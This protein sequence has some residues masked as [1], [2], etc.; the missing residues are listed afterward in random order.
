MMLDRQKHT[1]SMVTAFESSDIFDHH[2]ND[3]ADDDYFAD[4]NMMMSGRLSGH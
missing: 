1:T 2:E 3:G 4:Y